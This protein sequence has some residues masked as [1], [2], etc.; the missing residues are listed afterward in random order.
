MTSARVLASSLL[1][2]TQTCVRMVVCPLSVH[3][4]V[5]DVVSNRKREREMEREK[6]RERFF[7]I[8]LIQIETIK[9]VYL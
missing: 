1:L 3:G 6:E 5:T 7:Y 2:T 8:I 9:N 4:L